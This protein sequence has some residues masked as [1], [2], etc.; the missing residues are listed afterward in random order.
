MATRQFKTKDIII[1]EGDTARGADGVAYKIL[2]GRVEIQRLGAHIGEAGEGSIIGEMALI[3]EATRS[4]T[5]VAL[6]DVEAE[7]IT[8]DDFQ[9]MLANSPTEL[10]LILKQLVTRLRNADDHAALSGTEAAMVATKTSG[11]PLEM[12]GLTKESRDALRNNTL[13][14]KA[15]PFH[16]GREAGCS[17]I[18]LDLV[19]PDEKPYNVSRSHL[20][21]HSMGDTIWAVDQNSTLGSIVNGELIGRMGKTNKTPLRGGRNEIV[22]GGPDSKFKFVVRV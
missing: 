12:E 3:H 18:S 9:T 16:I 21:L 20:T 8:P 17:A 2:R 22:L 6:T 7:V 13:K 14:V 19:L 4:A 1:K 15:F 11:H 10:V 5:A